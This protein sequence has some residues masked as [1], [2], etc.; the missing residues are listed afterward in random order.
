MNETE[1]Y[2]CELARNEHAFIMEM[3]VM[4]RILKRVKILN[5]KLSKDGDKWCWLYGPNLIE[6][7]SGFGGTPELAAFS[8]ERAFNS[9]TGTQFSPKENQ[10]D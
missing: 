9:N 3:L 8:F 1:Q 10:N 7:V 5:A 2:K 4:E 6:G